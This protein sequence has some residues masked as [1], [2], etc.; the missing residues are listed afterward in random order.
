MHKKVKQESI[1]DGR[2]GLCKHS[3]CLRWSRPTQMQR[4]SGANGG[5]D[6][7]RRDGGLELANYPGSGGADADSNRSL[8]A[9]MPQLINIDAAQ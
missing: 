1:R 4:C 9:V 3:R 6:A 7:D 2:R 8:A 5:N